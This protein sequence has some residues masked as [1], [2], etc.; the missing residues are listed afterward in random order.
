M[1]N[2]KF[3]NLPFFFA[4]KFLPK[5]KS[6]RKTVVKVAVEGLKSRINFTLDPLTNEMVADME[7]FDK[8]EELIN[9]GTINLQTK[10]MKFYAFRS[11]PQM[12]FVRID[13]KIHGV[14]KPNTAFI[15]LNR[16]KLREMVSF[17]TKMA[18]FIGLYGK[19]GKKYRGKLQ[20]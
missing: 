11:Q 18:W 13:N 2:L 1:Q 3:S 20:A 4:G 9:F 16:F 6:I 17:V 10:Q 12:A 19:R 8:N 15:P 14:G 7:N 5:R